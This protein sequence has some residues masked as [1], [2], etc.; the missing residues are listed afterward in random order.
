MRTAIAKDLD[1][2]HGNGNQSNGR[3]VFVDESEL[4][5]GHY[6]AQ[7]GSVEIV[8]DNLTVNAVSGRGHNR[9][10]LIDHTSCRGFGI[11]SAVVGLL[12]SYLYTCGWQVKSFKLLLTAA[13]L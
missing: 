6:L 3:L 4:N 11:A 5:A 9:L 7:R 8:L 12:V 1:H 2:C 13:I 10:A